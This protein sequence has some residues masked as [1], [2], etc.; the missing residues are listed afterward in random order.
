MTSLEQ[1]IPT[2]FW[3]KWL[4]SDEEKRIKLVK[5]TLIAR[6][7]AEH[8]ASKLKTKNINHIKDIAARAIND[9]FKD[10]EVVLMARRKKTK[11][12]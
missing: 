5:K 11:H 2:K 1:D 7:L 9:Y 12:L 4:D 8:L 3:N 10:L 6:N